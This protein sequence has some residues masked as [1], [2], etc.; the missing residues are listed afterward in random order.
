MP[1]KKTA[2]KRRHDASPKLRLALRRAARA[3]VWEWPTIAG[4][5]A[6][7][8]GGS[9]KEWLTRMMRFSPRVETLGHVSQW[10]LFV[11]DPS[12]ARIVGICTA[13]HDQHDW[14][15]EARVHRWMPER[16]PSM[17]DDEL[18]DAYRE[19]CG[20]A[21]YLRRAI[22]SHDAAE[23]TLYPVPEALRRIVADLERIAPFDVDS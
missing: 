3:P 23:R 16:A 14:D 12:F 2:P 9:A 17:E 10:S 18:V 13:L 5:L 22:R 11:G 19:M 15:R 20:S 6:R 1:R 4:E 8:E 21:R 7:D